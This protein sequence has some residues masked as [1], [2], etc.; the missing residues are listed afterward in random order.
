MKFINVENVVKTGKIS[1]KRIENILR[2]CKFVVKDFESSMCEAND[3]SDVVLDE[4]VNYDDKYNR[5]DFN[6]KTSMYVYRDKRTKKRYLMCFKPSENMAK[7]RSLKQKL[8]DA[9]TSYILQ[10]ITDKQYETFLHVFYKSANT[11]I[12]TYARMRN[13]DVPK[14]ICFFY[15]GGNLYRILLS[16]LFQIIP[17][18]EYK[19]LIKRSDADFQLFINPKLS[20][21]KKIYEEAS[22]IIM[23]ALYSFKQYLIDTDLFNARSNTEVLLQN[24]ARELDANHDLVLD[25]TQSKKDF[26]LSPINIQGED[27]IMYKDVDNLLE[28][29]PKLKQSLFYIS[30]NTAIKFKR[31][32]DTYN[33]FDLFRMKYYFK[34][35]I[36]NSVALSVPSEVIDV[37]IPKPEDNTMGPFIKDA[38]KWLKQYHYKSKTAEFSFWAPSLNYMIKDIDGILFYQNEFPWHDQKIGKRIQRYFLCLILQTIAAST[39]DPILHLTTLKGE[40]RKLIKLLTCLNETSQ[41]EVYGDENVSGMFHAKY[42][43]ILQKLNKYPIKKKVEELNGFKLFNDTIIVIVKKMINIIL[44]IIAN[45]HSTRLKK[46]QEKISILHTTTYLGGA[47]V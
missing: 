24:F 42:K 46:L 40:F 6:Q 33:S 8:A 28:N 34:L 38:T 29:T 32:D 2:D 23:F 21:Y 9:S 41:C 37:S 25:P 19:D 27:Y 35:R 18:D 26:M 36:D 14:D 1:H 17:G 16:E 4:I 12:T 3:M 7:F 39:D 11:L 20:N 30:K 10:H 44:H 43:K 22:I 31:K 5:V 15:K 13:L 45:T 47:V